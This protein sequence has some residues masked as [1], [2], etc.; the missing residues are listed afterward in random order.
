MVKNVPFSITAGLP[1]TKTFV[2]T[3]PTSRVWWLNREDFEVK[4]QVREKPD[5]SSNLVLDFYNYMDVSFDDEDVVTVSIS[6]TGEDTRNLKRSGYY[7]LIISETGVV[8]PRAYKI[9][10]G[11]VRYSPLVTSA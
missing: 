2:I 10:Q 6:M 3:L 9:S 4:A 7:D 1:F 11:T 8:D 5:V